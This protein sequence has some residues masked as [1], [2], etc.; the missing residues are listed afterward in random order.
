MEVRGNAH[1]IA[2]RTAKYLTLVVAAVAPGATAAAGTV[3]TGFQETT[4]F[5][6]LS[7][8]TVVRF[9]PDGR[10]FVA[11]KRGVV[12]VFDGFEDPTASV[13]ADLRTEVYNHWD[14][15]LLGMELSRDWSESP[16]V[17]VSYTRDAAIGGTTPRWG[18]AGA[19]SDPCPNPGDDGCVVTG[20]ISR[21][22]VSGSVAARETPLVTDFCAQ[23]P[24]HTVGALET[25]P[26]GRLYASAGDGASFGFADYGQ[27]GNPKNGCGD[28][29]A[30]VGGTQ[31]SP[32]AEGG[33]LRSQDLRT[34]G[35]PL[36]LDGSLI[37]IDP[38]TGAGVAGNPLFGSADPNARRMLAHGFRNPYRFAVSDSGEIYVGDVGWGTWEEINRFPT[39]ADSV[40]NFG[41]PCFEGVGRQPGYDAADLSICENLY[42]S[43]GAVTAPFFAY[44]H[45]APAVPGESCPTGSSSITGVALYEGATAFPG[46]YR[47]ALFFADAVRNCIWAMK[48]GLDGRPDPAA[49]LTFDAGA[50]FPVDLELGPDGALYYVDFALGRIQRIQYTA[51]NQ[52]PVAVANADPT[53]GPTPLTVH[54]DGAASSDPEAGPI[55]YAW[56]LDGDGEYDDSTTPAPTHTYRAR[57][58]YH[59]S[60]R[61]TDDRGATGTAQVTIG[62]GNTPPAATISSPSASQRWRVGELITFAGAA[63]DPEDGPLPASALDWDLVMNHCPSNCHQHTIQSFG[64]RSSGSFAAP[65]HE[66]PSHLVLRLTATDSDGLSRSTSVRLD[67]RTVNVTLASNP[68]GL[69]LALN[70]VTKHAP[71]TTTV[72][73]G[74]ANSI[75]APSPQ[76]RSLWT[77]TWRTWSDGGARTHNV[78]ANATRTYTAT[79]RLNFLP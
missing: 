15:G 18:T 33:A 54:F 9:A 13:F 48:A 24:S 47:N 37:R 46:S 16:A 43:A 56:D 8:P 31:T 39:G 66:Y 2:R 23:Y 7:M 57:G 62:A 38:Q 42:A 5:S 26:S 36:G 74:S 59:V 32:T 49:V 71:F 75:S 45:S 78:T 40:L 52:P 41:W 50:S 19:D 34:S 64:D 58:T 76:T 11:E 20:R 70:G 53:S 28:P 67:P 65:D 27:A 14:R 35:D 51:A 61:V 6:E 25:D 63:S 21:L 3:P 10:I 68:T 72:I 69:S 73:E 12:K 55:T 77:Y 79:F 30:G 1:R 22:P 60:L 44:N 17:Y 29:P 4:A